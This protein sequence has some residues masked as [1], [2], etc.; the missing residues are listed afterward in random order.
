MTQAIL[1]AISVLLSIATLLPLVGCP[2]Y[3]IDQDTDGYT[4]EAGDCDDLEADSHPGANE[5]CDGHDNDCDGGVDEELPTRLY[6]RDADGDDFGNESEERVLTCDGPTVALCRGDCNDGDSSIHP[7]AADSVDDVDQDCGGTYGPDPHVGFPSSLYSTI[8][9]ALDESLEYQTIWVAPGTYNE[10]AVTLSK[11]VSL[12]STCGSEVTTIDSTG[13]SA[14][15]TDSSPNIENPVCP[16]PPQ[17]LGSYDSPTPAPSSTMILVGEGASIRVEGFTLKG[18]CGSCRSVNGGDYLVGGGLLVEDSAQVTLKDLVVTSSKA[19]YGGGLFLNQSVADLEQITLEENV[20]EFDG[21]GIYIYKGEAQIFGML[22]R[23]N[24]A[25]AV[26]GGLHISYAT[27]LEIANTSFI[28]NTAA[29]GGGLYLGG[30]NGTLTNLLVSENTASEHGGG[31]LAY[32][33][34]ATLNHLTVVGNTAVQAGGGIYVDGDDNQLTLNSSIVA[35]NGQDLCASTD[36]DSLPVIQYSDV[37]NLE[38]AEDPS[39]CQTLSLPSSNLQIDP[40]FLADG[41]CGLPTDL[42][43]AQDSPLIDGGDVTVFDPDGSLPDMGAYGGPGAADFDLDGDGYPSWFWP[44]TI[45]QAPPGFES[46]DYD[47]DDLDG[48]RHSAAHE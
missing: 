22:A 5:V 40:L 21:G 6:F 33:S 48:D 19:Q 25:G 37:L 31:L 47:C 32:D 44:G 41:E 11:S 10:V 2:A 13:V 27:E 30:N 36:E 18:G 20:A 15:G 46:E 43:L 28:E 7:G 38:G 39:H 42:H 26:G 34:S 24:T 3:Q 14:E 45:L 29:R 17:G 12:R 16:T 23:N 8:Q 1:P 4:A 35:Y 9:G